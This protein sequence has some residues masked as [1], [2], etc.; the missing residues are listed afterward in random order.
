MFSKSPNFV[1]RD[2]SAGSLVV[3][4][5]GTGAN[6]I[7]LALPLPQICYSGRSFPFPAN[8]SVQLTASTKTDRDLREERDGRKTGRQET[9]GTTH[10]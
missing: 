2:K 4:M 8:G 1:Q 3:G 5:Q 9:A 7:T 10:R 6:L